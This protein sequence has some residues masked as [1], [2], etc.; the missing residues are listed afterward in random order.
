[1]D[2]SQRSWAYV[3]QI[4]VDAMWLVEQLDQHHGTLLSIG[5][6]KNAFQATQ[7]A[8][9]QTDGLPVLKQTLG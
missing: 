1:M 8:A 4:S 9:N 3:L 5:L 7:R 2:D 6:F